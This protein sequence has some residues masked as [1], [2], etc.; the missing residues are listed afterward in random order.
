[1][2]M[3]PAPQPAD[4]DKAAT[5]PAH[6]ALLGHDLRAAVSDVIGGLRLID[7]NDLDTHTRLQLERVRAAGELLAR[8]MEE[9]LAAMLGEEDGSGALPGNLQLA[10]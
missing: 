3:R 7:Q 8:L 6:T 1:M 10:R 5:V 4:P 9:A 2:P